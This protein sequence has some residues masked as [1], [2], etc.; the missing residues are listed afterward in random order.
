MSKTNRKRT[1]IDN[2]DKLQQK[3]KTTLE[4]SVINYLGVGWLKPI[5]HGHTLALFSDVFHKHAN[6]SVREKDF[7]S[8][9][10][11]NSKHINQDLTR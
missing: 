4:R 6:C 3:K 1:N 2:Q 10:P 5:L 7:Y 8:S 9:M 11:K